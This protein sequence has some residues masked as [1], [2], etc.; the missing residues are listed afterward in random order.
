M[1]DQSDLSNITFPTGSACGIEAFSIPAT[2]VHPAS[3]S[4]SAQELPLDWLLLGIFIFL[5]VVNLGM[6][7]FVFLFSRRKKRGQDKP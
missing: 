4:T 5:V 7:L 6:G 1:S 3:F 2:V